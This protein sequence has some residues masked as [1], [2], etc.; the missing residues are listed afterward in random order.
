[1]AS[2]G[3]YLPQE[4]M[5]KIRGIKNIG[6]KAGRNID[7]KREVQRVGLKKSQTVLLSES[8]VELIKKKL[9]QASQV[10]H[11]S[12]R[13]YLIFYLLTDHGLRVGEVTLR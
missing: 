12:A 13:D 7:E 9:S 10:E 2:Q 6:R 1:M 4:E 8:H 5:T 11:E 3:D